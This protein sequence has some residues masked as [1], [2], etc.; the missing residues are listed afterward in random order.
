[1][2]CSTPT[3]KICL[4]EM[5]ERSESNAS[6]QELTKAECFDLLAKHHLGRI[7]VIDDQGPVVFPVN[8]VMDRHLVVFRTGEGI[9][10]G[11]AGM[12]GR[13]AFEIDG[14]DPSTGTG[15]SVIVR[16]EAVEVT[17]PV[18]LAR[19]RELPVNPWAP[20]AKSHY[21]RVLPALLTGRRIT[22]RSEMP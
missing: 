14:T 18:E 2:L 8:Y 19:L 6:W 22:A 1:M 13:V 15:W 16:G 10:L 9:K 5:G 17:D 11:A 4:A 12:R 3:A 7:A 21:V 20:G